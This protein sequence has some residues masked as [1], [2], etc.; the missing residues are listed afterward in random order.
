MDCFAGVGLLHQLTH[1]VHHLTN[2][3]LVMAT[4]EDLVIFQ[5]AFFNN[6]GGSDLARLFINVRLNDQTLG[7]HGKI[8][9]QIYP[10]AGNF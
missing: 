9:N 6:H 5:S 4:H 10:F 3:A 1:I 8:F 7:I 2:F